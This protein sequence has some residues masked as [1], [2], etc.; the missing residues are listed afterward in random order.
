VVFTE[1]YKKREE[2]MNVLRIFLEV[3]YLTAKPER[4]RES[5]KGVQEVDRVV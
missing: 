2:G 5:F 1:Q 3:V 4:E